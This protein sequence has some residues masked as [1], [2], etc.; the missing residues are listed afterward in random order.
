MCV[1]WLLATVHTGTKV[2]NTSPAPGWRWEEVLGR[3]RV[4]YVALTVLT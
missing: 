3:Q 1:L 4:G 2:A